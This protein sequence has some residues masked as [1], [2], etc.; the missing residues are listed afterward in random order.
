MDTTTL[1]FKVLQCFKCLGDIEYFCESCKC[2]MC[3]RCKE[4]HGYDLKTK[5]HNV[6]LYCK[7]NPIKYH[8][9]Q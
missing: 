4:T 5:D 3:P 1:Q 7:R 6:V 9:E 2:D 8:T